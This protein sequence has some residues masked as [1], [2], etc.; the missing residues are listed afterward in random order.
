MSIRSAG[1]DEDIDMEPDCR[2][3]MSILASNSARFL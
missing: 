3:A 2:A 1:G